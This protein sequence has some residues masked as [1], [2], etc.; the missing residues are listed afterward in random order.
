MFNVHPD[1]SRTALVGI[2]PAGKQRP[3]LCVEPKGWPLSKA[4]R[5]RVV[6]ELKQIGSGF[7]HTR[8]IETFLFHRAFPVDTRHN[9]KIFRERLAVWAA[10]RVR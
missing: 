3:V 2:G 5:A 1:V 4:D 6:T 10:R 8:P 7:A 9:A